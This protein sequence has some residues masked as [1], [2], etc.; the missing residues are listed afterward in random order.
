MNFKEQIFGVSPDGGAGSLE[1]LLYL[2]RHLQPLFVRRLACRSF[3]SSRRNLSSLPLRL[4]A[5]R[6]Q[7]IESADWSH[8]EEILRQRALGG[9]RKAGWGMLRFQRQ[10]AGSVLSDQFR[11]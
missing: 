7:H 5:G 4:C 2:D 9:D 1:I 10:S 11:G 3:D 6:L 8:R